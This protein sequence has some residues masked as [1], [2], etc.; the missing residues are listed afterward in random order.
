MLYTKN[1]GDLKVFT[2]GA[3]GRM[4][5]RREGAR[6]MMLV[7]SLPA[8]EA[9]YNRFAGIGGSEAYF[10]RRQDDSVDGS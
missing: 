7:Y 8:T 10:V 4:G 2:S 3:V 5:F 6:T 9:I 1:A